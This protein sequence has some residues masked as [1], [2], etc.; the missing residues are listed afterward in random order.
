MPEREFIVMIC[1]YLNLYRQGF[2]IPHQFSEII[3]AKTLKN[4][5]HF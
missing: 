2:L 1:Q 5:D 4:Q 3:D